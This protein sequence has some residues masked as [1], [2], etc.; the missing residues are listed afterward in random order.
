MSMLELLELQDAKPQLRTAAVGFYALQR[1]HEISTFRPALL[2][3]L[4]RV[5]PGTWYGAAFHP[6]YSNHDIQSA[7]SLTHT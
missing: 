5:L 2:L 4:C 6:L 3:S 7:A 1:P